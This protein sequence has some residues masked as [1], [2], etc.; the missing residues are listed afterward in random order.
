MKMNSLD[1]LYRDQL[2]DLYS[3]EKQIVQALPKMAQAATSAE[4]KM[5]F[6]THLEQTKIHVH[7]IE[8]IFGYLGAKPGRKKCEAMEGLIKEGDEVIEIQGNLMVRDAALIGA[9]QRIEHYEIA[10]YG[11]TRTL[12]DE[13]GYKDQR[14]LLQ[15]TL[16]EEGDT[17][18]IILFGYHFTISHIVTYASF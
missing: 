10:A 17:D 1:D 14:E 8:E 15:Q 2:N 16:N 13:L 18:F 11:L 4:L 6:E 5:G 9:A 7:R 12:A 3:A